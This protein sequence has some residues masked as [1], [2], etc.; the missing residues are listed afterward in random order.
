MNEATSLRGLIL[1][2]DAIAPNVRRVRF[3]LAER[4]VDVELREVD[5]A[6]GEQKT[7][8]YL[9]KNPFAQVPVL[10]D[11]SGWTLSES[12][13]ICRYLD[14]RGPED[15]KPLFGE[16]SKERAEIHMWARRVEIG[17]FSAAVEYG[18]HVH[19]HF[20]AAIDQVPQIVAIERERIETTYRRL[21]DQLAE[22]EFIAGAAFTAADIVAYSGAELARLWRLPPPADLT[23]LTRW[24]EQ[25]SQRPASEVARYLPLS[26]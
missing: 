2:V 13:A 24:H 9:A 14:E 1:Y 11:E 5:T 7:E 12:M 6:G 23:H 8:A 25:I 15:R 18:H 21:N 22:N 10:E 16:S 20:A 3:F 19:P 17:L 4:G 26:E